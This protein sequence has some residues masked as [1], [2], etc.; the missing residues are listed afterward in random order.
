MLRALKALDGVVCPERAVF[1]GTED[2]VHLVE[3]HWV[4]MQITEEIPGKGSQLLGGF[5]QP[6]QHGVG[7]DLEHPGR[8]ANA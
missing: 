2:G 3:L 5:P 1:D 4:D 7:V 8:G 6:P